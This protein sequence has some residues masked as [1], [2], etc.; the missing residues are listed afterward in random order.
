MYSLKCTFLKTLGQQA[1]SLV[2]QFW[3]GDET[4]LTLV[5]FCW[6]DGNPCFSPLT[7]F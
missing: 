2:L 6:A 3:D 1:I 4:N 5:D 7:I